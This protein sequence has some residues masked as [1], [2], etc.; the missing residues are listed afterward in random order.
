ME[1]E[2]NQY[3]TSLTERYSALDLVDGSFSS[4]EEYELNRTRTLRKYN[5]PAFLDIV[6]TNIK[7]VNSNGHTRTIKS[8][9]Y[10]EFAEVLRKEAEQLNNTPQSETY[11][12]YAAMLYMNSAIE[13]LGITEQNAH[14]V[15]HCLAQ[16]ANLDE[17]NNRVDK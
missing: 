7:L 15:V 9:V 11:Y 4:G 12:L 3:L 1:K 2:T 13:Y 6:N 8:Q 16:I 10:F 5:L 17:E 14:A